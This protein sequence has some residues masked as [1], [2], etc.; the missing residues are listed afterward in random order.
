MLVAKG[1]KVYEVLGVNGG[2]SDA[3]GT[4]LQSLVENFKYSSKTR[5]LT[6]NEYLKYHLERGTP[7]LGVVRREE[8]IVIDK[9]KTQEN[10]QSLVLN[11]NGGAVFKS[12]A[13]IGYY[14]GEEKIGFNFLID[15][16]EGGLIVFQTPDEFTDDSKYIATKGKFS[17]LEIKESKTTNEIQLIDG[18]IYLNI[19]VLLRGSIGEETKGL[20]LIE[21]R[22][23]DAIEEACSNKV[24]EYISTTMNKAQKEFKIGTFGID[25]LFHR[26]YPEEWEKIS[27]EWE[28]I[29]SEIIYD[30]NVET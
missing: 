6:M 14:T 18:S 23:K 17:S 26:K 12:D 13:L 11:V 25:A 5:S 1:A 19:N 29:F 10:P 4:Y 28:N 24:K 3:P 15:E 7:I 2:I 9:I 8:K 22:V 30:V 20:N 21:L 16:I 27:D